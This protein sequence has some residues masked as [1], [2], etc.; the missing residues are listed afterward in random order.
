MTPPPILPTENA[1]ASRKLS[2]SRPVHKPVEVLLA[3]VTELL[4]KQKLVEDLVDRQSSGNL[5]KRA[6][7]V[8]ELTHRQHE[9]E[10]RQKLEHLHA[11]DVAYI[12]EG[13]P[14]EE[15]LAVWNL[16]KAERDGEILLETADAVRESLIASMAS[17][18]LVA[19]AETLDTDEIAD[20][21]PDLPAQVMEDILESQD[22][23]ER[24]ELQSALSYAEGTVGA[25]MD[26]EEVAVQADVNVEAALNALRVFDALPGQTDAIFVVNARTELVGVLPLHR[27]LVS[28]PEVSVESIAIKDALAFTPDQDADEV[29]TAFERYDLICAPVVDKNGKLVGRVT[30][31]AV[32]DFVREQKEAAE[33]AKVGLREEEDIFASVWKSAKN[34]WTWLAINLLTAFIASRVIGSFEGS[35]TKLAA[36]A[37]LMPIVAGIGGNSGNQT[38]TLLI[39]SLALGQ[40]NRAS[41]KRL[42]FKELAIASINGI[43]WGGLVGLLA[44]FLYN[45]VALGL[46]MWAAMF[47]NLVVAATAGMGYPLYLDRIGRDPAFGSGVLLTATTDSMGFFIFLGLATIFL[48]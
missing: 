6:D 11:A 42:V 32:M 31:D 39:R 16:V 28:N 1:V 45:N 37:A 24:A 30:V 26:F 22:I 13:L 12:L 34:R 14:L 41:V 9:A 21:A 7:L 8:H 48:V 2:T 38:T 25:L 40:V 46:V 29:A 3:E 20:L 17:H 10:L 15:R 35:I 44:Y 4:R 5:S 33:L 19:A 18:E 23:E 27:V 36:L 43:V 47:L